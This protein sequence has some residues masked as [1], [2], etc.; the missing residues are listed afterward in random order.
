MNAIDRF[1]PERGNRFTQYLVPFLR[2]AMASL[3]KEKNV[4]EPISNAEEFPEFTRYEEEGAES[5]RITGHHNRMSPELQKQ[6]AEMV[7]ATDEVVSGA[8]ELKLN[9]AALSKARAKLTK[10]EREL[11]R[12]IYEEKISMADIAR[13][14]G[15]SR[16][17]VFAAHLAI[18][19][20]LRIGL[21]KRRP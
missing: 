3:W 17:A 21:K 12:L 9:L 1:D 16:Q 10:A 7:P 20:K 18:V 4:V 13:S 19:E 11:L 6:V 8:E 14:R 2:G 5:F 15:V